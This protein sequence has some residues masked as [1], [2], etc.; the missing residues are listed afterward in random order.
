MPNCSGCGAMI[1]P[2]E[3]KCEYCGVPIE[4][5]RQAPL[6]NIN[7]IPPQEMKPEENPIFKRVSIFAMILLFI[8]S[9]G[10]YA[11]IWYFLRRNEFKAITKCGK[12]INI[13]IIAYAFIVTLNFLLAIGSMSEPGL[14]P[15]GFIGWTVLGLGAYLAYVIRNSVRKHVS[16]VGNSQMLTYVMPAALWTIIFQLF[17]LQIHINKLIKSRVFHEK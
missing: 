12:K 5:Q 9:L 14:E 11:A 8:F 13:L 2:Q 17:Y 4:A 15:S 6:N 10:L 16:D 1:N 7:N 3:S